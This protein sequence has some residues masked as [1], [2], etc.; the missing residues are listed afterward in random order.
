MYFYIYFVLANIQH[1]S[2][3]ERSGKL[4]IGDQIMSI[5]GTSLVGLP[6][7]TV[8]T[9]SMR[10]N[11]DTLMSFS[12]I[13]GVKQERCVRMNIV[14]CPPVVTVIIKRPDLRHQ[15]GFSVQVRSTSF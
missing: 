4:N 2:P 8:H 9:G 7:S 12:V 10:G 3:A 6:L 13:K 11:C 1:S 5:N 14:S 15:L